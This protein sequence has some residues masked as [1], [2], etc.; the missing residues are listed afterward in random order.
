MQA[1]S[2]CISPNPN[3]KRLE[4]DFYGWRKIT[5]EGLKS[6]AQGICRKNVNLRDLTILFGD[7]YLIEDAGIISLA[8]EIRHHLKSLERLVLDFS[9]SSS[10]SKDIKT[11]DQSLKAI[12]EALSSHSE[13]LKSIE[14]S[15]SGCNKITRNGL[16]SLIGKIE[17]NIKN[18]EK[19]KLDFR[20]CPLIEEEYIERINRKF[21]ASSKFTFQIDWSQDLKK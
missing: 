20:R 13:S 16:E 1:F 7:C 9:L 11:S 3:L 8:D 6:F 10:S 17:K 21:K 14:L 15:F 18:L 12:G 2:S 4:I 5:D 19:V